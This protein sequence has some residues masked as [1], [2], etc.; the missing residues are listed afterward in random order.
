MTNLDQLIQFA[1]ENFSK[2]GRIPLLPH[3]A[4]E[5]SRCELDMNV[6]DFLDQFSRRV[7]HQY[8]DGNLSFEVADCAMNSLNSYCLFRYDVSLPS[9]ADGVYL[10]FDQGEYNHSGD[11]V[12]TDPE[13][14]YTKQEIKEIVTRDCVLRAIGENL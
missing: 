9:Y 5:A 4:F 8:F 7:A 6:S 2:S 14:K 13:V 10:A 12:G 3:D 1:F 11:D